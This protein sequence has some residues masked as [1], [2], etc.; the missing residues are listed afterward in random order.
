MAGRYE[1]IVRLPVVTPYYRQFEPMNSIFKIEHL[2]TYYDKS[3]LGGNGLVSSIQPPFFM[4]SI[5]FSS[6]FK[7]RESIFL[8]TVV[9]IYYLYNLA[10]AY[11]IPVYNL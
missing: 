6:V 3:C 5:V 2:I 1:F 9:T 10:L 11:W 4:E 8:Y 7:H